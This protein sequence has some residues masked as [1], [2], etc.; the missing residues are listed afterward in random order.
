MCLLFRGSKVTEWFSSILPLSLSFSFAKL[1]V[2]LKW[3]C[4]CLCAIL[5]HVYI[6]EREVSERNVF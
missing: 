1:S 3:L 4:L 6:E 5:A 2:T